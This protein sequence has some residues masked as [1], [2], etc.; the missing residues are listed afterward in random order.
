MK[1]ANEKSIG[2]VEELGRLLEPQSAMDGIRENKRKGERTCERGR[3]YE[4]CC[5]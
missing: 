4:G 3:T 1:E 5:A 2:S